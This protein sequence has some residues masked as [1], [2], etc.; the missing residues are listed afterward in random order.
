MKRHFRSGP[1]SSRFSPQV[2]AA[3]DAM[4]EGQIEAAALSD[5]DNQPL[6]E[7]RLARMRLATA[8]R[9]ARGQTGLSQQAFAKIFRFSLGRL[10]DLEQGRTQPD[11][12][13]EAYLR[14]IQ[15][16]P[17]AVRTLLNKTAA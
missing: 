15:T 1:S 5:P 14:M 10:R 11:S 16:D 7:E 12:A 4:T 8:A 6:T 2:G 3:L 13:T 9:S 17:D